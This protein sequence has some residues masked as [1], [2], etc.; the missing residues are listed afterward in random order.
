MLEY[1][2]TLILFY[3]VSKVWQCFNMSFAKTV[4]ITHLI[5]ILPILNFIVVGV[6]QNATIII[7]S[8]CKF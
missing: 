6:R 1:Y 3:L 2:L 5:D 7:E 4:F 8:Q